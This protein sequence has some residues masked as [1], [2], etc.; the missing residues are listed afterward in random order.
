MA[1]QT[2][3]EPSPYD[4][5]ILDRHVRHVGDPVAIVAGKD[6]K[7]VD[8]AISS[9][10]VN[11][12]VLEPV[13]DFHKALDNPVLV[14]PEDTWESICPVGADNKRNLCAHDE[15]SEGDVD[16]VM[17]NCDVIIDRV[18]H[19]KANQQSMMEPFCTFCTMDHFGRLNV[20]SST[21]I[22]FHCRKIIAN[23]LGIPKTK[24]RVSKPRIGGG[25][26]AKQTSISEIYPAFVTWKTGK[27][28]CFH[29]PS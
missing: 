10:N 17:K 1:G 22:V 4:R 2:Y 20:V 25:F 27:P 5:L 19:T 12:E 11:Y 13:L 21:Q 9:I 23:A 15:C 28:Y 6:E 24:V 14:H 16:E 26:G 3:P 8:R 29:T 18:Y 7:C